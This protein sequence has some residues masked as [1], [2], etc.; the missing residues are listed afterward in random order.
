[1]N[2]IR[3][4]YQR[5]TSRQQLA[6]CKTFPFSEHLFP[7]RSAGVNQRIPQFSF[8]RFGMKRHR[9]NDDDNSVSEIAAGAP[10]ST[11]LFTGKQRV[12]A[13]SVCAGSRVCMSATIMADDDSM[14]LLLLLDFFRA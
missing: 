14:D 8:S 13:S 11:L 6:N 7:F 9:A 1:M 12:M 2:H 10:L 4:V 3:R 5:T